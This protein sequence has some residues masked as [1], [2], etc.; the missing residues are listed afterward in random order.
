VASQYLSQIAPATSIA[1]PPPTTTP[2]APVE[3]APVTTTVTEPPPV[4]PPAAPDTNAPAAFAETKPAAA[5][6]ADEAAIARAREATRRKLA[7]IA[8][9]ERPAAPEEPLP[10]RIVSHEGVVRAT[11]SIQAPTKYALVDPVSGR[12]VNYLFTTS[13]NLDLSKWKG[14]RVVITG[15]EGLDAR[16]RNTPV[17]TIQKIHVLE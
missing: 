6:P 15:E 3:P 14:H 16:W 11:W 8:A 10:P 4:A 13:T 12:T 1:P 9:Q 7:E 2:A 17:L 5:G